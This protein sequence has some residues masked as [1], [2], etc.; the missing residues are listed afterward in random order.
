MGEKNKKN[1][2]WNNHIVWLYLVYLPRTI[3]AKV[4]TVQL[5]EAEVQ[6]KGF[7]RGRILPTVQ[8]QHCFT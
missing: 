5:K 6:K 4:S 3:V 2:L 7:Q 8:Q 1:K